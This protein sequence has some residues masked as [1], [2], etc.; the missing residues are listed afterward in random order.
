[1]QS[2]LTEG[3]KAAAEPMRARA[4]ALASMIVRKIR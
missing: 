2:K 3:E 1:M 4:Q